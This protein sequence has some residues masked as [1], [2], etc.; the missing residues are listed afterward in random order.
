MIIELRDAFEVLDPEGSDHAVFWSRL[1]R[2]VVDE[3]AEANAQ[4]STTLAAAPP[5]R[6]SDVRDRRRAGAYLAGWALFKV[7]KL[8]AKRKGDARFR[9]LLARLSV[10][11]VASLPADELSATYLSARQQFG[12]LTIPTPLFITAFT[13][14]REVLADHLDEELYA[15]GKKIGL[16]YERAVKA[17]LKDPSVHA[18][19]MNALGERDVPEPQAQPPP[20]APQPS[21]SVAAEMAAERAAETAAEVDGSG[22][23]GE[24]DLTGRGGDDATTAA[25]VADRLVDAAR[26]DDGSLDAE[27]ALL[28]SGTPSDAEKVK[29]LLLTRLTNSVGGEF[30]KQIIALTG[31][32]RSEGT[33][34]VR[35]RLKVEQF[36]VASKDSAGGG[37][38]RE[39]KAKEHLTLDAPVVHQ[40]LRV[41]ASERPHELSSGMTAT[42]MQA[43]LRACVASDDQMSKPLRKDAKALRK[44]DLQKA[45]VAAIDACLDG[46]PRF[47][48]VRDV[49][50]SK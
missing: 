48:L 40:L 45:L 12:G 44:P 25:S 43:V 18:S 33:M 50:S 28:A 31:L 14:A 26:S 20:P 13:L 5:T 41:V 49:M 27:C 4:P 23:E 24:G 37:G 9:P 32:E 7:D 35:T 38:P 16:A 47:Q 19:F 34:A 29:L 6:P 11:D 3:F 30:R 1:W 17:T 8:A 42:Q 15:R 22:D 2:S 39:F 21:Q 10:P 36:K 46:L